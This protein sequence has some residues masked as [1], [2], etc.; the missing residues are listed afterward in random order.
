MPEEKIEEKKEEVKIP[1]ATLDKMTDY[2]EK[3]KALM[4]RVDAVEK[5]ALSPEQYKGE[6]EELFKSMM[7]DHEKAF[8][9]ESE[10]RI[11][12]SGA[13]LNNDPAMLALKAAM[14]TQRPA[15][16]RKIAFEE[17]AMTR[18]GNE[19]IK[20]LQD[21]N[22]DLLIADTILRWCNPQYAESGGMRS[23]NLHKRYQSQLEEV[24]KAADIPPMDTTDTAHFVPTA[25]SSQVLEL[26]WLYGNVETLFEHLPMPTSPFTVPLDLTP[27]DT[28][29]D[30]VAEATTNTNNPGGT[31]GQSITDELLTFTA[32]KMGARMLTSAELDEDSVMMWIPLIKRRISMIIGSTVENA[33]LNGD[34]TATHQDSDTHALGAG[35][36]RKAYK[37][38]RKHMLAGSLSK[39]C[40][41]NNL[42]EAN[43][44]AIKALCGAYGI[45][46]TEGCWIFGPTS[47]LSQ[48]IK[49]DGCKK[50][51]EY[52]P[53]A[54]V[55]K[56]ELASYY[57]SPVL[58]SAHQRENLNASGVFDGVTETK[59]VCMYV[60]KEYWK[61]GDR[62]KVTLKAEEWITT[63]QFNLVAFR[64]LDFQPIIAPTTTYSFGA[65]GYNFAPG[66]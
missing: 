59:G 51:N 29:A 4:D 25:I 66:G 23:L 34:T 57:G 30:L 55:I 46:P 53:N 52:G 13:T 33:D 45:V 17:S 64:R 8:A 50:L 31:V 14:D 2:M 3:Q 42:N 43:L 41:S 5:G 47:Y 11:K 61:H 56:G 49:L 65:L 48:V 26:P 10:R 18:S 35:D 38:L 63:D 58:Y 6:S 28:V 9:H 37:G 12:F 1:V 20:A 21:L 16:Q 15:A 39:D 62:R 19:E 40:S 22:D 24:V 44:L 7:E 27:V 60:N 54:T 32:A 36:G